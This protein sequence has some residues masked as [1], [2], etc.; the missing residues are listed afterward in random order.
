MLKI[1][2]LNW[3]GKD[4]L[5]NLYPSLINSLDDIE[6]QWLIKDNGSTDGSIEMIESWNNPNIHLVKQGHNRDSFAYGCNLL[7]KESNADAEDYVLL[8]NNDIIF[9]DKKSIKSMIDLMEKDNNIGLVGAKLKFTG[10]DKVQH[11]GVIFNKMYGLPLHFAANQTD[12]DDLKKHREFQAVTGAVWL[13]KAKYYENIYKEN[14]SG[15]NGLNENYFFCFED[16]CASL[17][18]RYNQNKK[19][20]CCGTTDIYHEESATLKKNPVNKLFFGQNTRYFIEK[21]ASKISID[22]EAYKNKK[23]NLY[24]TDK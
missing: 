22:E 3:Q 23:Y 2:T 24:R 1:L 17:S 16:I 21:W 4:K 12:C 11:C 20:V 9:N 19:V 8:L 7:F 5:A 13:T 6:Y 15:L 10:T 14:K 18:I